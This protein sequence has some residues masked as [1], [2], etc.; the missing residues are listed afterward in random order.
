MTMTMLDTSTLT[1]LL[2]A[3][4]ALSTTALLLTLHRATVASQRDDAALSEQRACISRMYLLPYSVSESAQH[5]PQPQ[6]GA[7]TWQ[8]VE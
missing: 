1:L 7:Q 4:A 3:L 5:A 2:T 6:D 8:V